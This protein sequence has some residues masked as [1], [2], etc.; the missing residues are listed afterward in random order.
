MAWEIC[1][2]AEGWTEIRQAL[3]AWDREA[4]IAAITD[5]KFEAV[6]E[7]AGHE[8][9]DRAVAAERKRLERLPHDVLVGRAFELIEENN[10]CD[11]GGWAYWIDRDGCHRVELG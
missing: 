6:F 5:D 9:A 4:L 3:E 8:H 7:K 2:S 1:I 11:N 10:T